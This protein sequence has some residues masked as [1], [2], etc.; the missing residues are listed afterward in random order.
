MIWQDQGFLLSF[1]KFCVADKLTIFVFGCLDNKNT[2]S[3]P[4]YPVAP[5]TAILIFLLDI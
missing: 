1:P 5:I 4:V 3:K 2:K